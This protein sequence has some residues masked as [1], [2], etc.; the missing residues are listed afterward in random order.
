MRLARKTILPV[1]RGGGGGGGVR[2]A[3]KTILPVGRGS[4]GGGVR[5]SKTIL[6]VGGGGGGQR[7]AGR[8]SFFPVGGGGT[9][10]RTILVRDSCARPGLTWRRAN[11][12]QKARP[13]RAWRA[14]SRSNRHRQGQ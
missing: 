14:Q 1:G 9:V 11:L 13:R 7:M 3:R 6:P 2:L 10:R 8:T 4:G 12:L 5:L